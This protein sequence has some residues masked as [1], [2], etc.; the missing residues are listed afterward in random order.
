MHR[1]VGKS[2][3]QVLKLHA[4]RFCRKFVTRSV[5]EATLQ[6]GLSL[7]YASGYEKRA[8]SQSA[9]G[10][11]CGVPPS[12]HVTPHDYLCIYDAMER[13]TCQPH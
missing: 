6:Y 1:A 5:S 3:R 4:M 13:S 12:N 7:A 2:V 9:S 8:T 10:T 11:A